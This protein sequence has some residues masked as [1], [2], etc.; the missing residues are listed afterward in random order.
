[1]AKTPEQA[2]EII[3][4]AEVAEEDTWAIDFAVKA[5]EKARIRKRPFNITNEDV[6]GGDIA[7]FGS[8]PSCGYEISSCMKFCLNCGQALLWRD[9]I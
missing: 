1:M 9:K 5:I 7:S 4:Q 3:S 6:R 8:C 2:I